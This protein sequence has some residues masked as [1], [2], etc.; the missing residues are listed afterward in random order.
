MPDEPRDGIERGP[1]EGL[2]RRSMIKR[3]GVASA[4]AWATP[5]ITSLQTPAFAQSVSRP[6]CP[7]FS[8]CGPGCFCLTSVE[9]QEF[10]SQDFACGTTSACQTS[11]DCPSGWF[12]QPAQTGEVCTGLCGQVCVPPCGTDLQT[13]SAARGARNRPTN[14]S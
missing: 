12:C 10:C 7:C 3:I 5:V 11:A 1:D 2:S 8:E 9:G 6:N 4:V 14:G 13:T